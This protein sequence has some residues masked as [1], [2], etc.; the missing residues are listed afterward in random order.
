MIKTV[1]APTEFGAL[2]EKARKVVGAYFR[3]RVEDPSQGTLEIQGERYILVRAA[4]LS[5]DFYDTVEEL[6]IN[7]TEEEAQNIARQVLFDMSHSMG[8]EDAKHFHGKLNLTDPIE[9]LLAGPAHFAHTGWAFV[10]ISPESRPTPDEDFLLIYDHLNSF[11]SAAWL[12]SGRKTGFSVCTMNSGYSSGWCEESFGVTLVAAE[13]MCKAKGDHACRFIMAPPPR[14]EGHIARYALKE[15]ALADK[16]TNCEVP[17]FFRQKRME[18]ALR[19]SEERFRSAFE[20]SAIGVAL[21]TLEGRWLKVNQSLSGTLGYS[22]DE[23]LAKTFQDITHCDDV[24]TYTGSLKDILAGKIQSRQIEIRYFH[25]LGHV[26]WAQ[27]SVSLLHDGFGNPLCFVSQIQDITDKRLVE[28]ALQN[29]NQ[30]LTRM[31]EKFEKTQASLVR[32]KK[33]ASIGTLSAGIA[34][35]IQNPLQ[36][37]ANTAQMLMMDERRGNIQE[38]MKLIIAQI[39]RTSKIVKNLNTF[40]SHSMMEIKAL[41]LHDVFEQAVSFLEGGLK[42]DNIIIERRFSSD[43]PPIDGDMHHLE[44]LFMILIN[45]ARDAIRP[46]GYG[47][48][49]MEARPVDQGIECKFA[50]NGPGMP[51]DIIDQI[52]DPFFTTKEPGKGIGLGLSLAHRIIEDHGGLILVESEP[53]KGSCFTIFLPLNHDPLAAG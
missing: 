30:E 7:E 21:A 12:A 27:V 1:N 38:K 10:E 53:G 3:N 52:F 6:F 49:T 51:E 25:K 31:M 28:T 48:I 34:H 15:P 47:T 43:L 39:Q 50:D 32:S 42:A 26:I 40:A 13:I 19:E 45:N 18:A 16:I 9:K 20:H 5:V 37:I 36:I 44:Q 46:L 33:F 11:E 35:E 8:K 29:K 4:S 14:M 24:E 17:G 41:H 22:A 23:L 2:F